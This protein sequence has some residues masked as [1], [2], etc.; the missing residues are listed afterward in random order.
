[1]DEIVV[2]YV[3]D[4][5]NLE[6]SLSR[7]ESEMLE[8]ASAGKKSSD[9]VGKSYS[10]QTAKIKETTKA[11]EQQGKAV[12]SLSDKLK[13]LANNLPLANQIRQVGELGNVLSGV[14]P[15]AQKG[16]IGVRVL[17]TAL[18]ATGIP[19]LIAAIAGLI[20]YFKRT[21]EGATRLAGVMAAFDATLD[22][23]T[24]SIVGFGEAAFQAG[25]SF[26]NFGAFV[27]EIAANIGMYLVNRVLAPFLLTKDL[28]DAGLLALKGEGTKAFDELKNGVLQ[29]LTGFENLATKTDEFIDKIL[30]AAQAAYEWEKA[31]DALED[32]IRDDS[33]AIAE[34][35]AAITKLIIASKNKQVEDEKA[36]KF[37]DQASALEKENLRVQLEN[38]QARLKLIQEKNQR[39]RESV[40]QDKKNLT[41]ELK[42]RETTAKRRVEILKELRSIN[43]DF[44]KEER[45]QEIKI[46]QLKQSSDNLL[47]KIQNRRDAKEEEIF[48]N[49]VKRVQQEEEL[50]ENAAKQQYIDGVTS[51][52]EL[53]QALYQIKLDGLIA[54]KELLVS[55]SRDIV[56]IDKAILDLELQNK[57]KS[58]KEKAAIEKKALE[59]REK[60]LKEFRDAEAKYDEEQRKKR[61]E[62]EKEHQKKLNAIKETGFAIA[63]ELASGFADIQ[64]QKKQIEL[65][66]E[67]RKSQKETDQK[68]QDL[69][70][71]FDNGLITEEQ[72][73]S[74]K[75]ALDEK[76]AKKESEIK[77]KKFE[78]DKK[79][80]LNQVAI[81]T[82]LSIAK[83][84]AQLGP[85]GGALGAAL[86]AAMGLAQAAIISAQPV[87]KFGKGGKI[88]GRS[89]SQGGV[90]IEGE[91]KEWVIKKTQSVKHDKLLENINN[92]SA[93]KYINSAFVMPA[94][95][96]HDKMIAAKNRERILKDRNS[97]AASKPVDMSG[98]ERQ[99]KKN[100]TVKISNLSDLTKSI[101]KEGFY[102]TKIFQ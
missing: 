44:A 45:D 71:Q 40:N 50:K 9:A 99:L 27:G 83:A 13:D 101:T 58:E 90:L 16:A 49:Q 84:F 52:E 48:Q 81:D 56:D 20:A 29:F 4:V 36:L 95:E 54:Q 46:I 62:A 85:I 60:Q 22:L 7:L 67:L 11:T 35:D 19:V 57:F 33:K 41:D 78:A 79:A 65:D 30:E 2:K 28:I 70:K 59:E 10:N 68:Q 75:I 102:N 53:E 66:D 14:G 34:N 51:A 6:N 15:A 92:D 86:A 77:K 91:G 55:N 93:E 26:E 17:S 98:V 96:R 61:E 38:E 3:G 39:E 88:K 76:R 82:A 100:S 80:A 21:D 69:Q 31:M 5:A 47:E 87:P 18:L 89:H 24:G 25:K 23:V 63:N 42:A 74:K 1:V 12:V 72:F 97:R 94:I 73:N 8:V 43:D 37:L 64:A 32:K